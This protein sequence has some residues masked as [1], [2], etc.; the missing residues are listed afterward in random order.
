MAWNPM[1]RLLRKLNNHRSTEVYFVSYPK[2]GSTWTRFLLGRYVQTCCGLEHPPLFDE[3]DSLGRCARFCVGPTIQFTHRPLSWISQ[4]PADLDFA[5]VVAPY[6]DKK[7]VLIARHPLDTL[8]SHWFHE[9]NQTKHTA[10][11]TFRGELPEFLVHPVF[12]LEKC[13]RFYE[14]WTEGR[15]AVRGFHL[16]RYEDMKADS[17]GGFQALLDFL[18]IRVDEPLV[19]AAV[20]YASFEN[21]KKMETTGDVPTYQSSGYKV[22]A[23]GDPGNQDAHH[24]R[25]GKVGG[26]RDY[27]DAVQVAEFEDMVNRR[28]PAWLGYRNGCGD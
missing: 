17:V 23:T 25:R 12:G 10:R 26:Y 13:S 16:L 7:V 5:N 4:T 24:V 2:T 11:E 1:R 21:M 3:T 15:N 18:Q 27:L 28:V 8:V 9:R 20:E 22:F 19:R 6:R 14:V